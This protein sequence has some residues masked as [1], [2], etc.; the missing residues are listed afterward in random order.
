[1]T[2]L[3]ASTNVIVQSIIKSDVYTT[4][5]FY[6]RWVKMLYGSTCNCYILYCYIVFCES[7][8]LVANKLA[9]YLILSY[10]ILSLLFTMDMM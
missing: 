6:K 10:L 8:F 3:N 7:N 2:L 9:S 5:K 4:S 1:M